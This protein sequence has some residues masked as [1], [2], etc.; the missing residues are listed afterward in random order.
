[1][2]TIVENMLPAEFLLKQGIYIQTCGHIELAAWQIIQMVEGVDPTSQKDVQRFL[3]MKLKT[4]D[5]LEALKKAGNGCRPHIG[6]R[7]WMLRADIKEG[8]LNRNMAAHG[9]WYMENG[10]KLG[11]E[12]YFRDYGD[13]QYKFISGKF[14]MRSINY[15]VAEADRILRNAIEIRDL[16]T[17]D[18]KTFLT[19]REPSSS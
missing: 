4:W 18:N 12:H 3:Q 15:A 7:I 10:G 17:K 13:K 19:F 5:I 9:A 16:L 6:I 11:V 8:I 14:L 2:K 1:M